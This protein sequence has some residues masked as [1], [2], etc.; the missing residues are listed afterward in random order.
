MIPEKIR[1]D[2]RS[3][4]WAEAD[5]IGWSS[6]S[7]IDRAKCYEN[8]TR[9]SAI[10]VRLGHFMDPRRV[11]VYI[12]DSLLKPYE[13][14]RLSQTED[15]VWQ[16]L[17]L[18]TPGLNAESFIKP[19]GRRTT[20][21]RVV[22]WGKS[23]DWKFVLFAVFERAWRHPASVPFGVVLLESGKTTNARERQLV[24]D[25]AQKLGIV[26]IEWLEE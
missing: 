25:A 18:P 15:S 12:K 21:G 9:S 1:E 17:A 13:R 7:D 11:R 8:W 6:L 24:R 14:L 10:G 5:D 2:I 16:A 19:H 4:L 22:C 3:Q 20:D 23:R 26:R